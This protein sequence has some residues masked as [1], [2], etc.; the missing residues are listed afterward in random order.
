[1]KALVDFA[2]SLH[3]NAVGERY[4]IDDCEYMFWVRRMDKGTRIEIYD[5]TQGY[6]KAVHVTEYD[7][8]ISS[9]KAGTRLARRILV[10]YIMTE[11]HKNPSD[12]AYAR[13]RRKQ[14]ELEIFPE[15]FIHSK[16]NDY[17]D[18]AH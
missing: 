8:F 7:F 15:Y 11:K 5:I 3:E 18:S 12:I 2:D 17:A 13:N 16:D 4:I 10:E 6:Q 9:F 1:M 14:V